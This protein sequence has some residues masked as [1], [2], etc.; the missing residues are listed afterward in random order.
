MKQLS[1]ASTYKEC[2]GY[3]HIY[4]NFPCKR[5]TNVSYSNTV[6]LQEC[7]T[8]MAMLPVPKSTTKSEVSSIA[9]EKQPMSGW[10]TISHKLCSASVSSLSVLSLNLGTQDRYS[11]SGTVFVTILNIFYIFM[12]FDM[13]GSHASGLTLAV[14]TATLWI[15]TIYLFTFIAIYLPIVGT[16]CMCVIHCLIFCCLWRESQMLPYGTNSE[17]SLIPIFE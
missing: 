9:R 4:N 10:A 3:Q 11:N 12:Y 8:I 7:M 14:F 5:N 6:F 16:T 13:R 17:L 15:F 1:H 2:L